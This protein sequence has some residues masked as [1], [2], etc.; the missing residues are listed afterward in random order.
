MEHARIVLCTVASKAE[1]ERIAT[2][3]V[4]ER[5]AACVNILDGVHSVYR[6]QGAIESAAEVQLII[7]TSV[8][9]LKTLETAIQRLHSYAVPEFIVLGVEGGSSAYL[10]WLHE[11]LE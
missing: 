10:H 9:K 2:T 6:W 5:L 4:E 1:A 3:L 11:S 7:K 8:E